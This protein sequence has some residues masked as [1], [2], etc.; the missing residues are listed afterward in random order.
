MEK[1]VNE[2]EEL[3]IRHFKLVNGDEILGFITHE[4]EET[5]HISHPYTIE[6]VGG[7]FQ[8][9]PW[10]PLSINKTMFK[11]DV[12]QIIESVE[13]DA[14]VKAHFLKHVLSEIH[15]KEAKD[16]IREYIENNDDAIDYSVTAE[17]YL[18][19]DFEDD[20]DEYDDDNWTFT[21]PPTKTVH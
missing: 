9:Q 4:D 19:D 13:V 7:S 11:L 8:T 5:I 15:D 14:S 12:L 10:F 18:A 6:M 3:E 2:L 16:N 21:P 20:Y 1:D 17:E